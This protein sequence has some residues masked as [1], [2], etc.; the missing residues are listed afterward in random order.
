MSS[1]ISAHGITKR[2][3]SFAAV[4]HIS[5][6]VKPGSIVGFLGPNGAGKT[7]TIKMIYTA[8]PPDEGELTVFGLNTRT[9]RREIKQRLGVVTQADL[10]EEFGTCLDNLRLYAG[11]FGI[12]WRETRRRAMT[13]LEAFGL[14]DY[15]NRNIRSLSG[16][17]KRRISIAK[18][19]ISNPEL[20]LLDE[21]TIG[22][23]PQARLMVWDVIRDIQRQG[24]TILMTTHYMDE[25]E[26]LCD[27]IL[28]IDHGKIIAEGSPSG[29]IAKHL[30]E[31]NGN[32]GE[33]PARPPNLEDVFI[34][35]TGR[36][37]RN[38]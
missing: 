11:Y 37:I 16:G 22:L 12:P 28:I 17:M 26:R 38:D 2:F 33:P 3:G 14:Q 9:H 25:A 24:K 13:L 34:H 36:E 7:T 32:G 1:L 19:L 8:F 15:A 23:D 35:L 29:L 30:L 5:F 20:L 4:D 6:N 27:T 18:G 10:L 31:Q 21:P